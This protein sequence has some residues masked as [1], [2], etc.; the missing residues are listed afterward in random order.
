MIRA[1]RPRLKARAKN[2]VLDQS[3]GVI[4]TTLIY[5]A[6]TDWLSTIFTLSGK[7]PVS[8]IVSTFY[9]SFSNLMAPYTD[10]A[11]V[12]AGT[13]APD[14][15]PVYAATVDFARQLLSQPVQQVLL[16]AFALLFLFSLVMRY[17][18]RCVAMYSVRGEAKSWTTLF[19]PLWIAGK[20]ILLEMI[21]ATLTYIGATFMLFPGVFAFYSLRL[22]PYVLL[23]HPEY[24]VFRAMK[25]SFRLTASRKLELVAMDVSFIPLIFVTTVLNDFGAMVGGFTG[26]REISVLFATLLFTIGQGFVLP[27]REL[28][29]VQYYEFY[30]KNT[31]EREKAQ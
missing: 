3:F 16:F 23:D 2:R 4:T 7:N 5:L 30:R 21:T 27:Y 22:A 19:E 9:A 26:V 12:T 14:L 15:A 31:P 24:N 13:R 29:L 6:L 25:E 1:D 8:A 11:A 10:P 18:L 28:T 17:G 20:I